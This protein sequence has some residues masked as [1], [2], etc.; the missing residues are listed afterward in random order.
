MK[1]EK[2]V[3]AKSL[4]GSW[5]HSWD[6]DDLGIKILNRQGRVI[7][8]IGDYVLIETYSFWSGDSYNRYLVPIAEASRDWT[9]YGTNAEMEYVYEGKARKSCPK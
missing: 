9:F 1:T 5:C 3:A 2:D 8:I 4:V 6:T 7:E